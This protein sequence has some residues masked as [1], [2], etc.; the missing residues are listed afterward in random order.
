MKQTLSGKE[1][2]TV[3]D[4]VG[5]TKVTKDEIKQL[6]EKGKQKKEKQDGKKIACLFCG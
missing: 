4:R 5:A 1:T 2:L 3:N 6:I